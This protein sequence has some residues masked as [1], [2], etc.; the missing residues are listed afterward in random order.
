MLRL[1]GLTERFAVAGSCTVCED[2]AVLELE[3]YEDGVS[4]VQLG[5]CEMALSLCSSFIVCFF[6]FLILSSILK[7]AD[8]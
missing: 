5:I 1:P 6:L 3:P 7:V 8:H 2:A 4:S